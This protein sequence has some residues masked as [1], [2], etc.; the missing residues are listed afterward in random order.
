MAYGHFNSCQKYMF[1]VDI[2]MGKENNYHTS[3][4][5]IYLR[6]GMGGGMGSVMTILLLYPQAQAILSGVIFNW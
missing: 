5:L 1:I 3:I 4:H 6:I 2:T